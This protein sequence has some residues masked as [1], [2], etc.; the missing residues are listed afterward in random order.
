MDYISA[1]ETIADAD[2]RNGNADKLK[3]IMPKLIQEEKYEDCAGIRRA[4]DKPD[5]K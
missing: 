4:L 1:I 3:A 5:K 2:I